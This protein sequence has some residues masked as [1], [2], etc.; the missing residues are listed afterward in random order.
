MGTT[1]V[2]A[3]ELPRALALAEGLC[4]VGASAGSGKTH[5]LTNV[6]LQA[7]TGSQ[8]AALDVESLVAV[9]YTTR[10]ATEL[11]SRIRQQLVRQGASE[12]ALRLPLAR[13]GTVHAVCLSWVEDFA[14]DA[15]LPPAVKVLPDDG[16]LELRRLL[17]A[18]IPA[19]LQA[20]LSTL[21]QRLQVKWD[22]MRGRSDWLWHVFELIELAR[23]NR[24]AASALPEMAQRSAV[25]MAELLP[26]PSERDLDAALAGALERALEDLQASTDATKTTRAVLKDMRSIRSALEH[27]RATW[28]DWATLAAL[29]PAKKSKELIENLQT[30]AAEFEAHPRFQSELREMIIGVFQCAR[31]GLERY[32]SWKESLRL[33][34]YVDMLERALG[35]LDRPEVAHELAQRLRLI[36]V[37]EFQDTSPIQL[38][39]FLRLHQLTRRSTWVGDRKQ[40]IFEFAGADPQLMDSVIRWVADNGGATQQ[41]EHNYR[42]RP[43]LVS[44]CSELFSRALAPHGYAREEVAVLPRRQTPPELASLPPL[45]IFSLATRNA[46]QQALALARGVQRLLAAPGATPIVDRHTGHARPLQPGDVA[47]LV[48]TNLE[49]VAIAG[50]LGQLGIRAA[51]P[52]PGLLQTPEGTLVDAALSYLADRTDGV[53]AATLDALHGFGDGDP[54]RWLAEQI[55]ASHAR[56]DASAAA[57]AAAATPGA[58]PATIEQP[59]PPANDIDPPATPSGWRAALVPL[60]LQSRHLSPRETLDAAVQALDLDR[61]VRGWPDPDQRSGNLDAL[62]ALASRYEDAC[63]VTG[64]A[65]SLAGLLH[66]FDQAGKPLWDGTELRA[67]DEQH[68]SQGP[69]AV[70]LCTYHRSKGLE[71]PVVILASL[72]AAPR[73]D[74]FG[75]K[76]QS[77]TTALDPEH[78]LDGRWIRYCPR[79]LAG[80]TKNLGFAERE[81]QSEQGREARQDECCERARLLYVGF[82]RARDHLILAARNR[83]G[84]LETQWLDELRDAAGASLLQLPAA[85]DAEGKALLLVAGTQTR[86]DARVWEIDVEP[87]ATAPANDTRQA[88]GWKRPPSVGA[89]PSY[90]ITPSNAAECWQDLPALCV[91]DV[92]RIGPALSV[93][94]SGSVDWAGFGDTV[95]GFLAADRIE[96]ALDTRRERARRLLAARDS[97]ASVEVDALIGLS[98]AL[99]AFVQR[100]WPGAVW[101]REVPIRVRVG[102]GDAAQRVNGGIDLLLE[103]EDGYVVMDHKTYGNPDPAAVREHSQQYLPQLAAYGA[104]IDAL[105]GKRVTEYWL[106]FGVGGLACRVITA[107]RPIVP[108]EP[109]PHP[110]TDRDLNDYCDEMEANQNPTRAEWQALMDKWEGRVNIESL[111]VLG[112][113]CGWLE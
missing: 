41:L 68:Y 100:R 108:H 54:D 28:K 79:P 36:V 89:R 74:A 103:T 38:E 6:V 48:R 86:V 16:G 4:V 62:R 85:G 90:S 60:A 1:M 29:E 94:R 91:A 18:S 98:D 53:A 49:A 109:P 33:V 57:R 37:D 83:K 14:V 78:P 84:E 87:E 99:H 7:L 82:T 80:R 30:V 58:T 92:E 65:A 23:A 106:H 96:H 69:G 56:R 8:E 112:G 107:K 27:G 31:L 46:E 24:I 95:H 35:L 25:W 42:S 47:V 76:I 51:L 61:F 21:G 44:L 111:L 75:V 26:P 3:S 67:N 45:G 52:R 13:L 39:L 104:A 19:E 110:A 10:A 50:A 64:G 17:E 105:G 70:V 32:E 66:Y 5:H 81:A 73:A 113:L 2:S 72:D 20:R 43:E 12:S 15:G 9:T 102:A 63:R 22:N 11:R 34:D 93:R 88:L 77:T 55:R 71:W 59:P 101:Q 40:C 97:G